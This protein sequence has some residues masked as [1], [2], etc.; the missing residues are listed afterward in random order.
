[1]SC[2]AMSAI[3]DGDVSDSAQGTL[4]PSPSLMPRALESPRMSAQGGSATHADGFVRKSLRCRPIHDAI[5]WS[6]WRRNVSSSVRLAGSDGESMAASRLPP[7]ERPHL[8]IEDFNFIDEV[9]RS[10]WFSPEARPRGFT[11]PSPRVKRRGIIGLGMGFKGLWASERSIPLGIRHSYSLSTR[12]L[13]LM[14][15]LWGGTR[16]PLTLSLTTIRPFTSSSDSPFPQDGS[17]SFPCKSG[18]Y[19]RGQRLRL[20][21]TA[22]PLKRGSRAGTPTDDCIKGFELVLEN[23]Y[24]G[25]WLFGNRAW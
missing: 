24:R 15:I 16:V 20:V 10:F 6:R 18:L 22:L 11:P 4:T 9:T 3:G 19:K 25:L 14:P 2:L 8:V 23:P 13:A 5:G 21:G 7:K 12:I 1:L 17:V